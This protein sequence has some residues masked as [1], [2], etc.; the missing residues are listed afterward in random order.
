MLKA[1][2]ILQVSGVLCGGVVKTSHKSTC[3]W[4]P[5]YGDFLSWENLGENMNSNWDKEP[6]ILSESNRAHSGYSC[7]LLQPAPTGICW[8]SQHWYHRCHSGDVERDLPICGNKFTATGC[9]YFWCQLCGH[10]SVKYRIQEGR[11]QNC[12]LG[13]TFCQQQTP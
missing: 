8:G 2:W 9:P 6:L 12:R 4:A 1:A 5:S 3:S 7:N 11:H 13:T 10:H